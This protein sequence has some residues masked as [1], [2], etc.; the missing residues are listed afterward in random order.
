MKQTLKNLRDYYVK[1]QAGRVKLPDFP[2]SPEVRYR[3]IFEGRVQNVGFRLSM[4]E[5]AQRLELTGWVKNRRDLTVEAEIQGNHEKVDF[6]LE[7]MKKLP[8]ASVK[9]MKIE[10]IEP[11]QTE[12]EFVIIRQ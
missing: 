10:K 12:T 5:L 4:Y 9:N 11:V 3:V 6:L 1:N 8:Q 7:S 2:D